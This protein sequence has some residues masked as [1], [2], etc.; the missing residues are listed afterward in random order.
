MEEIPVVGGHLEGRSSGSGEPV[1]FIHGALMADT[2]DCFAA[3]PVMADNY[4]LLTYRRRGFAGSVKH[5]GPF[6]IVQ[7]AA[8]ASAALDHFG[9]ERAHVVGHSYGGS[10]ALQLALDSP[11]RVASLGLFE[12]GI[13]VVPAWAA[14][15]EAI[16]PIAELYLAGNHA[17][18][19]TAFIEAVGGPDYQEPFDAN[20]PVGWYDA[21][22]RDI[23]T[24]F[25]VEIP[26]LG[27]WI[28]AE[29]EARRI[30]QPALSVLGTESS[31][32]FVQIDAWLGANLPNVERYRLPGATHFL[33]A[34]NPTDA[35]DGL[36]AFLGRHPIR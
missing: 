27:E 9:V 31:E 2:Y 5:D 26:A 22:V 36:A 17:G 11:T 33:Q 25:D 14:F 16:G 3:Q 24:F 12:P 28:F 10:T 4:R 19:A 6:S 35:A 23:P 13:V 34:M 32:L 7:Q 8:D 15:G 18:A 30:T 20:L 21:M 1:L 29:N